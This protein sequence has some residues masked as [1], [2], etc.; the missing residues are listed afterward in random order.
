MLIEFSVTNFRSIADRQVLSLTPDPKEKGF[1]ENRLERGRSTALNAI[2]IYGANSSGKSNLIQAVYT[3]E[4][5]VSTSARF[6]STDPLP[7]QPFLLREGYNERPTV[8]E[9]VIAIDESRYRYLIEY[10]ETSILGEWLFRKSVGREVML[11]GRQ[12]DL[13]DPSSSLH[14]S[15]T[16]LDAAIE[17]TKSNTLFLSVCDAFN[18]KEAQKIIRWFGTLQVIDGL[19][20]DR[21]KPSTAILWNKVQYRPILQAYLESMRLGMQSVDL[22]AMQVETSAFPSILPDTLGATF[23][24]QLLKSAP[25]FVS[26]HQMYRAD[27]GKP[28]GKTVKFDWED[29]ESAGSQKILFLSGPVVWALANAGILII[30]EIEAKSHPILTLA[31]IERFLSKETNPLGAQLIFATHD[32]NILSYSPLRL[33]QIYFAEK[34]S[35]E[36]TNLYSLAD[37]ES[38]TPLKGAERKKFIHLDKERKY[39]EGRY[40]AIPFLSKQ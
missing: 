12:H 32:T 2:A 18:I 35:W 40:G 38:P 16:V 27:D 34:N 31:L 25:R 22:E 4:E 3:F 21:H 7:Y 30:D 24:Q 9:L 1:P 23:L 28:S 15:A 20:T 39:L 8:F 10:N 11:F 33:D 13:I 37:F 14:A 5:L 26:Q 36:S 17:A 6:S 19:N 29:Q